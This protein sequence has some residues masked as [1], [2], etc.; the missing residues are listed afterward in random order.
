VTTLRSHISFVCN[1]HLYGDSLRTS[2]GAETK[3]KWTA[4]LLYATKTVKNDLTVQ[5]LLETDSRIKP[6]IEQW[7]RDSYDNE[8]SIDITVD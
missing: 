5:L 8:E 3:L 7:L 1:A 2:P 6:F 4:W